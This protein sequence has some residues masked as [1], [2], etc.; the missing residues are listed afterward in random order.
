MG[1]IRP[2]SFASSRFWLMTLMFMKRCEGMQGYVREW[3]LR[4]VEPG[5]ENVHVGEPKGLCG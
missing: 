1:S 4:G 5:W 2:S 3:R